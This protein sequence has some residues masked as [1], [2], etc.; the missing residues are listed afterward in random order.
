MAQIVK[1]T[2]ERLKELITERIKQLEEIDIENSEG[3][4]IESAPLVD[5]G[6][7]KLERLFAKIPDEEKDFVLDEISKAERTG[8]SI[9]T[10]NWANSRDKRD[11]FKYFTSVLANKFKQN[12]EEGLNV[13]NALMSA[14]SPYQANS[15]SMFYNTVYQMVKSYSTSFKAKEEF[16]NMLLDSMYEGIDKALEAYNSSTGDFINLLISTIKNL[17]IDKWR[18]EK[19]YTSG[20]EKFQR[21]VDSIDA[22]IGHDE[23]DTET[24]GDRISD[25]SMDV[26]A[27][28]NKNIGKKIWR[29]FIKAIKALMKGNKERESILDIY[30]RDGITKTD[31]V[32]ERMVQKGFY[33]G[34]E[35]I[36]G[37][38]SIRTNI[39]RMQKLIA[40]KMSGGYFSEYIKNA[41][42][43]LVNFFKLYQRLPK[44]PSG[45]AFFPLEVARY[46][47]FT[48][49]VPA[50]IAEMKQSDIATLLFEA[51]VERVK[52]INELAEFFECTLDNKTLNEWYE[53]E[54]VDLLQKV[55]S[56][57]D[58]S[59]T[60]IHDVISDLHEITNICFE[61][62][63]DY[64]ELA[65][66]MEK[67]VHGMIDQILDYP[68]RLSAILDKVK[69]RY[70]AK[71]L[72][73]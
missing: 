56:F 32:Y 30:I 3:G 69:M 7:T 40:S 59:T 33:Q 39:D 22:P 46:D 1:L 17:F 41:T 29:D 63:N 52:N 4:N 58:N 19:E 62:K 65:K 55:K 11:L 13:R 38:N 28:M 9:I 50:V 25:P 61:I 68:N 64:P 8:K 57:V 67:G 18:K 24:I 26:D 44:T 23:D 43:T 53:T 21:H 14:F 60:A 73:F 47:N 35:K 6:E 42:K 72:G 70:N 5:N 10:F 51:N 16:E 36:T 15:F 27:N 20:G 49:Y 12:P 48:Q 45:E 34:A 37:V 31:E 2:Q 66:E 71:P 54:T